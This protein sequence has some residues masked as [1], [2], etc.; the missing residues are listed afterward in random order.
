MPPPGSWSKSSYSDANTNEC[1]E[2]PARAKALAIRD[3][4][5]PAGLVIVFSGSASHR[6]LG[7]L[8]DT[9]IC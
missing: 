3:A 6:F 7:S 5:N 1:V 8:R 2:A 4:E 9:A